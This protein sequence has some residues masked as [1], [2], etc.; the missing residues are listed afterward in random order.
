MNLA[1]RLS[2]FRHSQSH[3]LYAARQVEGSSP[4]SHLIHDAQPISDPV[5]AAHDL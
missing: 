2:S 3:T 1:R 5:N 4:L